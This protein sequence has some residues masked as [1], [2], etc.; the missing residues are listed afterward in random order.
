MGA[1]QVATHVKTIVEEAKEQLKK[2]QEHQKRYYDA[3]YHQLEYEVGQKVLLATKNLKL[4]GS[5]KLHLRWVRSFKVLQRVG[6]AAY[7]LDLAGRFSQLHPTFYV[8]Y[9]KPHMPGGTSGAPPEP[10]ELGG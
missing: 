1:N 7:K 5:R 2:A 8:S 9:L 6:A 10:V 4:P 3:H